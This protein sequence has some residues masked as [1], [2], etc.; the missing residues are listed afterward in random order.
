MSIENKVVFVWEEEK[1][2]LPKSQVCKSV[3]EAK[4]FQQELI[5]CGIVAKEH[6][7]NVKQ[8]KIYELHK[9]A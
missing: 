3:E 7:D 6:Y 4:Q 2:E 9:I 1:G 8:G 5:E